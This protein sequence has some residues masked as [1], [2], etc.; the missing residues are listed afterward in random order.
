M[1]TCLLLNLAFKTNYTAFFF[2]KSITCE[3]LLKAA[4]FEDHSLNL[5]LRQ[6]LLG[7][8]FI[9]SK[10]QFTETFFC[11]DLGDFAWTKDQKQ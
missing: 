4:D 8:F 11:P 5:I 3:G 7:I 9:A 1:F 10:A 6:I 2:L